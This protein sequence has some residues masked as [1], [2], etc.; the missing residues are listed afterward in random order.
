MLIN[1][2]EVCHINV[3]WYRLKP[4]HFVSVYPFCFKYVLVMFKG[5]LKTNFLCAPTDGYSAYCSSR[6][7]TSQSSTGV[8]P[9]PRRPVDNDWH[10][11]FPIPWNKMPTEVMGKL[12]NKERPMKGERLQ[13]IKL[14]ISE[15]L[16]V[17]PLPGKKHLSEV[18]RK[19]VATYPSSFQ[20][21]IEGEVV[22][23]GYDSLTKQLVSRVDNLKR[24]ITNLGQ[25]RLQVSGASEDEAPKRLRLD[26]Y[27]CV[28]WLPNRLP[29]GETNE[30][31]KLQQE[32]LKKMFFSN[33]R[34]TK[35]IQ[36]KMATTFFSQ[37]K[38]ITSGAEVADLER[39]WPYLFEPHGMRNHFKELTGVDVT[40]EAT[41]SK[42]QRVVSFLKS[43]EKINKTEDILADMEMAKQKH[44]EANLPAS[45][46]LLLR[47]FNEDEDQMFHKVDE[48]C[49][50]SEVDCAKL[51]RTPCI[52][53]CG[54]NIFSCSMKFFS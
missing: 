21:V 12:N 27:G 23:S 50:A 36:K 33:S 44:L 30:S 35:N 45:L 20:D 51:P 52:I 7:S 6:S 46:L 11:N 9:T 25:K 49:L 16:T 2:I 48:V 42:S 28:N 18:A 22:G 15:I 31:Q 34:D 53:A 41:E 37:R 32:E 54:M 29:P 5:I 43:F 38:D 24:G 3:K 8:S 4:V 47:H 19:M 17:C 40:K 10:Y 1:D 13:M 39:E 14:I 26:S